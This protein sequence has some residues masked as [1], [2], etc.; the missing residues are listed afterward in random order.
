MK[1]P[2][3]PKKPRGAPPSFINEPG[4][5]GKPPSPSPFNT[6]GT[7]DNQPEPTLPE[8]IVRSTPNGQIVI[9]ALNFLVKPGVKRVNSDSNDLVWQNPEPDVQR[10]GQID[11]Q[12]DD[13]SILPPNVRRTLGLLFPF[14][15]LG[16]EL[17]RKSYDEIQDAFDLQPPPLPDGVPEDINR[18][19]TRAMADAYRAQGGSLNVNSNRHYCWLQ[20]RRYVDHRQQREAKAICQGL[21]PRIKYLGTEDARDFFAY[22]LFNRV[23]SRWELRVGSAVIPVTDKWWLNWP[24]G[25]PPP[26][27]S[28]LTAGQYMITWATW[29]AWFRVQGIPSN[30]T[31]QPAGRSCSGNE[32]PCELGDHKDST[33]ELVGFGGAPAGPANPYGPEGCLRDIVPEDNS[34]ETYSSYLLTGEIDISNNATRPFVIFTWYWREI[35]GGV[36]DSILSPQTT[37][38]LGDTRR[39]F[40]V[41]SYAGG[42]C[43]ISYQFPDDDTI[44]YVPGFADIGESVTTYVYVGIAGG[45]EALPDGPP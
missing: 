21:H 9:F 17:L 3:K 43:V 23:N 37:V 32:V 44:W 31:W 24:W 25:G 18:F 29:A 22:W 40:K 33:L 19:P 2:G 26:D 28:D 27:T 36:W 1:Q 5:P 11:F 15:S 39:N 42:G 34:V 7:F 4:K 16:G 45:L 35:F 13:R 41:S 38:G 8:K 14:L 6:K 20:R 30:G 12:Y 10:I